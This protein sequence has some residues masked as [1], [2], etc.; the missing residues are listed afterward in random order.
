[1]LLL[2]H[3]IWCSQPHPNPLQL[4]EGAVGKYRK[5]YCFL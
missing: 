5:L 2:A 4:E 1:M 3:N